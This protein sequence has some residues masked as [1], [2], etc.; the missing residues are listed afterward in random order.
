MNG[1]SALRRTPGPMPPT[2]G[3]L[4]VGASSGIGRA[5]ARRMA[6]AGVPVVVAGRDAGSLADVVAECTAEGGSARAVVLDVR[7]DSAVREVVRDASDTFGPGLAV[8]H[9]AA[10]V[11]YGPFEEVPPEVMTDVVRTDVL[12]TVS[13][14]RASLLAFR[15][16]GGGHLVV[17]G[18]LLGE[19]VTPY[20][21]SYVLSKWAVHG[22][23]RTLQVET[24]DRADTAVSLVSPGGIDTPV[25]RQAASV[26]GRHGAPPPPVQE[27][28]DV[29]ARVERVLRRPRR[30]THVG[31]GN[32]LVVAGFRLVPDVFD[33][34]VTPLMRT[35]GLSPWT[36]LE[37][38]A[39]NVHDARHPAPPAPDTDV[40]T[41]TRSLHRPRVSRS[42]AASVDTVWAVLADGRS[43]PDW[44][45][46]AHRVRAVDPGWPAPGT[47]IHHDV[48][49]RLATLSDHTTSTESDPPH[50]LRLEAKGRPAG[51][52]AVEI[53]VVPDGPGTC[54]VSMAEDVSGGPGRLLPVPLRQ[55]TVLPRNRETLRRLALVAEA[56]ARRDTAA[57]TA[58]R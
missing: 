47:S 22:L 15:A 45:V 41:R 48:G 56:R 37:E 21:S 30:Q 20:M 28:D 29:A 6:R 32:P 12:G 4:V 39:G 43:Y 49:G 46:G 13:V 16:A 42:V 31:P 57:P 36:G 14:A 40:V 44:V 38:T 55:L 33:A 34:L 8:V 10:V 26:L 23:V 35:L 25:Y 11:A 54:T 24:R 1:L 50:R 53:D 3:V 27:A 2:S 5:T 18:S 9:C 52:A 19:I 58:E 51:S 7:D 17:I